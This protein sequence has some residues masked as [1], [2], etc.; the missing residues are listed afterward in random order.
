MKLKD[1]QKQLAKFQYI[2]DAALTD[3]EV[4]ILKKMFSIKG[5][6]KALFRHMCIIESDKGTQMIYDIEE[7]PSAGNYTD[8]EI[9]DIVRFKKMAT[10]FI[11]GRMEALR[12]TFAVEAQKKVTEL[13]KKIKE[14]QDKNDELLKEQEIAKRGVSPDM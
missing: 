14:E 12:N 2:E 5:A 6:F 3:K 8:R 13:E 7:V 10:Q 9:A 1:L 11:R 4:E